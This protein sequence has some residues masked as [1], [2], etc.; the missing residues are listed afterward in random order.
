LKAGSFSDDE[1]DEILD[2][3]CGEKSRRL[4]AIGGV[5]FQN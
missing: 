4:A 1:I 3:I 5:A 2:F